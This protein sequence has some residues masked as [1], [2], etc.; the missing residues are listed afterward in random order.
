MRYSIINA[1]IGFVAKCVFIGCDLKKYL[2]NLCYQVAAVYQ[3]SGRQHSDDFAVELEQGDGTVLTIPFV[4]SQIIMIMNGKCG[5][6]H[7]PFTPTA[8]M[9]DGL[10]DILLM[11]G[12]FA[13]LL[14]GVKTLSEAKDYHGLH[15]YRKNVHLYRGSSVKFTN[16]NYETAS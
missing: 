15:L 16:L 14:D 2:G 13:H 8:M 5:G 4:S 7:I 6:T 9:N 10:L 11:Q 12:T 3:L 1:S